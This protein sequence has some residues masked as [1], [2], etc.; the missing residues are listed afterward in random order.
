MN[1]QEEKSCRVCG[2]KLRKVFSLGEI[3]PSAYLDDNDPEPERAPLALAQCVDCGLVQLQ[4]TVDLDSMYF[5][6]F[7]QS[8]NNPSMVMALR[9]VIDQAQLIVPLAPGDVVC[10]IACNDGTTLGMYPEYVTTIG[11]DPARNLPKRGKIGYFINDYF[12]ASAYDSTLVTR[13]KIVTSI[14]VFYDLPDPK[15]FVRDVAHILA[16]DGIWI[17]QFSDL[18][19]MLKTNS[20]D[21]ICLAPGSEI[22]TRCGIK[23]IEDIA[24]GE[25]VLTHKGRWRSVVERHENNF[26]GD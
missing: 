6:Y 2:G 15:Q 8:G 11:F 14:A 5:K 19:S 17:M 12:D 4:H 24:V 10:D 22:H 3:Y 21:N 25:E 26:D 13:A 18:T 1:Y 16:D 9:D 20:V 7:Y 23:A